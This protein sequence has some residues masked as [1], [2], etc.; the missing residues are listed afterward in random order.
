MHDDEARPDAELEHLR[1]LEISSDLRAFLR[2]H[3]DLLA[4]DRKN[5]RRIKQLEKDLAAAT[6]AKATAERSARW[7]KAKRQ[8]LDQE[9]RTSQRTW[10]TQKK[11]LE[12]RLEASQEKLAA[13]VKERQRLRGDLE[14][15][16]GSR[17]FRVGKAVLKP[18]SILRGAPS[19]GP[20]AS[21][22]TD[23]PAITGDI[24]QQ[25]A[26]AAATAT[27]TAAPEQP[28]GA[29][30]DEAPK[31][32]APASASRAPAAPAP[33]AAVPTVPV[34][35][36]DLDTLRRDFAEDP[37]A[38]TLA[39][40]VNRCWY[41]HGMIEEPARLLLEHPDL[42]EHFND[43]ER[44]LAERVLGDHRLMVAG[45]AVPPRAPGAAYIAEP[46]R[47]LY[48]VHSTPVFNSNGYSTRTRGIAKGMLDIGVDVRVVARSGYPWD[49]KVDTA[50]PAGKRHT[51][52]LDGVPYTH[53][54]GTGLGTVPM[55]HYLIEAADA[56]T[57]EARLQRPSV[58]QSASNYRTALPALIAA[59]RLGIP[60]IYEVR[61]FWELSQAAAKPAWDDSDQFRT[62]GDL[63]CL[64]AREADHVLAIT[65]QVK[66][67]L[68]SRGIP[69]E[70][71][72][73]APN[74]VDTEAFA[75]IPPDAEY[76]AKKGIRTDAPVLGF[77]GSMVSY[78]GLDSLLDASMILKE[79]GI[80][81]Q[82]VLA[83]S[84]AEAAALEAR[85]DEIGA[86]QVTFLGRLP[87][88]EMPRLLSTFDIMPIPRLS[89][90][91]TEMVSP[92]KP[93]EAFASM[94]AVLL[95]DVAPHRDLAGE[96]GSRARLFTAGDASSL[97][98][99]LAELIADEELRKDLGRS[100]R[101]WTLDERTWSS[102]AAVMHAAHEAARAAHAEAV[103]ADAPSLRDITVGLIADEF[104]TKTLAASMNVVPLDRQGWRDQL[105][106][107]DLV[108][109]ESAWEGNSGQWHRG[110]GAYGQ[111]EHRDIRELLAACRE[112]GLRTAFW[113][114]EDPIHIAR[115]RPTAALCDHVF[116]TDAKMIQRYLT[117]PGAITLTASSLPFYAQ[118][119][120]HNPLPTDRPYRH[121]TAYAGTYYG[122][123]Y[124]ERSK[125]LY[126]MLE[127]AS[128]TG[129]TI[130][131]RQASNPDSPYRFPSEFARYSEG[132]L[133]YDDVIDSYKSH[134]AHLN[135]NSV[136]DSP[137]MFSR[138]VVEI[139]ACG[140]IA[141]SGPGRGVEE[142]FGGLIPV[143]DDAR[144][145]R[146]LLHG[147]ST[148]P[149]ARVF[150]AWRQ[151]RAVHRSH[152]VDSAMVILLRTAGIAVRAARLDTY[153]VVLSEHSGALVSTVL[154]QSVRPHE[155]FVPGGPSDIT[156]PLEAAGIPVRDSAE[157]GD[158]TGRWIGVVDT[159]L[160]RTW[161]EDL[162]IATRFGDWDRLDA[163]LA[164]PDSQGR[165]LARPGHV[166]D[167]VRGLVRSRDARAFPSVDEALRTV[168]ESPATLLVARF[169]PVEEPSEAV[170]GS[171]TPAVPRPRTVLIAG[172]DLKFA[173][174]LISA[175]E[176]GGHTVLV[177]RWESHT[178]HDEEQSRALLARA[179]TV[180]CEWGLGNAVWYSRH[181][182]PHQRLIVRS[183]SQ[184]LNRPYLRRTDASKVDSFVFV[185]DL[186][187]RAAIE[188]HGIPAARSEVI[189]NF[190]DTAALDLP[191]TPDARFHL[192]FVGMVPRSKRLDRA[193]DVLEQL[194][195]QD[196]RYRLFVKGKR[197][198][199]YPWMAQRVE[200]MTYYNAVSDRIAAIHER[201]PDAVT[202]EPHGDDM[203][204]WYRKIGIAISVSEFESFHYTIADGAASGS[205]PVCLAWPGAD[206]LYPRPWLNATTDEMV[207]H[208]LGQS[209]PDAHDADYV[210]ERYS[211]EQTLPRL[212]ELIAPTDG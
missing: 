178:K 157:A 113:N 92:L 16:R 174:A 51:K 126:R 169:S 93:L 152:T 29:K 176:D 168:H 77:A 117:T 67:D 64:V 60:F 48:C 170:S 14:R 205:V 46:D 80:E 203:A 83:G 31:T 107:L 139:A 20:S 172:H 69:A 149:S 123:R 191:K 11:E 4:R 116:T 106:G 19:S 101:L 104:T 26:D 45:I 6:E 94:K 120:L 129:L 42:V 199:D 62:I 76:A 125:E 137:T 202:F 131:D 112:R 65:R 52:V 2:A 53:L 39:R 75:P 108:L 15:V 186:I 23:A 200:E 124:K 196:A 162:L 84:G 189:P 37:S 24:A 79:R 81:H 135:G 194:L 201:F 43:K 96:N 87:M 190:V 71:I 34:G 132:S 187:R 188:S 160:P 3:E 193:L 82:L 181:V 164:G 128:L 38:T 85:R 134:I 133:P 110:I 10:Q 17:T 5:R 12:R 158:P 209:E 175:L 99:G 28:A 192:G 22:G 88:D 13:S 210:R 165:T 95:S 159:A 49:H 127:T 142:T 145:W 90:P 155:V 204:Q 105:A 102:V 54:P 144:L 91:V 74:A 32:S 121:T 163:E 78:E 211:L 154:D 68:V 118:P 114:K 130:Y 50:K 212:L 140:G 21:P 25:S 183:H 143:S 111:D 1:S 166:E 208:I 207:Q 73:V 150:E 115:F 173:G 66:E 61:G 179:D 63:E 195:E 7:Q 33:E 58:I 184:E 109:V 185:G 122:D 56:F 30:K 18:V 198:E 41:G 148:D 167:S 8:E 9:K 156:T 97:A 151:M 72:T 70:R 35:Q 180:F 171:M 136:M 161:F 147:W 153:S 119:A 36:R 138:R 197:P 27:P 86:D 177:D 141:L 182:T 98:D 44:T 47:L 55:D 103:P 89:L 40:V 57:R 206:F 59:R 100:S 146:T